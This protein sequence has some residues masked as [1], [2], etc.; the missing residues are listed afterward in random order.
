MRYKR[1]IFVC[2]NEREPGHPRGCCREK[3]GEEVRSRFKQAIKER[4]LK[5]ELRANVSGCL[6]ICE[7]GVSAVV[8]PDGVWYGGLTVDDVDEIVDRHLIGGEPVDRLR[9][10]HPKYTPAELLD[11]DRAAG[12]GSDGTGS[13]NEKRE[14]NSNFEEKE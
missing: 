4:G 7:F 9:V 13:E 5:S 12:D 11:P 14:D 1:H 8:Y 10:Q 2:V 6:D 3:G